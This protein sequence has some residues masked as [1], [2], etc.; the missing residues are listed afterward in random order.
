MLQPLPAG[1]YQLIVHLA[2][3]DP[4][5]QGAT[6]DHRDWGA[7]WRQN[8]LDFVRNPEFQTFLQEQHFIRISWKDLAKAVDL[9]P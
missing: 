5:I 2:R 7:Q 1:T 6:F 3:N 9:K 4:E 8:D